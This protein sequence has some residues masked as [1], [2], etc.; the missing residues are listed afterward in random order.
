[1]LFHEDNEKPAP[2]SVFVFGSNLRGNHAGGAALEAERYYG[3]VRGYSSGHWGHSYA[4]PTM[5]FSMKPM[6]LNAISDHVYEFLYYAKLNPYLEFYVTRIGCGIAGHK[7]EDIAPMF[8][9]APMN[10]NMPALW[11]PYLKGK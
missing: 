2:S 8:N 4:I 5:D 7:N 11:A 9:G 10:C 6:T 1:M 3:A